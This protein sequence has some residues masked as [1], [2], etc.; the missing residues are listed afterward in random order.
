MESVAL[1]HQQLIMHVKLVQYR[2]IRKLGHLR[3]LPHRVVYSIVRMKNIRL[4][5]Y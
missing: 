5:I 4:E 3:H 2:F 1:Q